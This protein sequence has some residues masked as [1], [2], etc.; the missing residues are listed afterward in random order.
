MRKLMSGYGRA[1]GSVVVEEFTVDLVVAFEIFHSDE[2]RCDIDNILEARPGAREDIADVFDHGARLIAN[3]EMRDA[4]IVDY[5]ARE[6]VIRA[7]RTRSRDE[8]EVPCSLDVWIAAARRRFAFNQFS[9][10]HCHSLIQ[11]LL[12]SE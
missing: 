11:M 10:F 3:F 2:K 8:Q 12:G 9:G 4:P 7:A 6:G 1:C 5:D